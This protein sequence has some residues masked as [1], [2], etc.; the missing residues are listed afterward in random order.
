MRSLLLLRWIMLLLWAA[1]R[2]YHGHYVMHSCKHVCCTTHPA[3]CWKQPPGQ[4]SGSIKWHMCVFYHDA[5]RLVLL[6]A[7]IEK[8]RPIDKQLAYQIDKLLRATSVAQAAATGEAAAGTAED[9]EG[10]VAGRGGAAAAGPRP[11]ASGD[12]A[13]RFR[14]NPAALIAKAPLIGECVAFVWCC[15]PAVFCHLLHPAYPTP[16]PYPPSVLWPQ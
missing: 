13:L 7:Y 3:A 9:E 16:H 11:P 1:A 8:I 4:F 2:G 15:W 10:P 14:P 5:C 6:R 12:D